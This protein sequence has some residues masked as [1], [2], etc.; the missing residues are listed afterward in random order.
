MVIANLIIKIRNATILA[1][2]QL[3]GNWVCNMF[4]ENESEW[5]Y[6][7][8]LLGLTLLSPQPFLFLSL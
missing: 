5:M 2:G 6:P 1:L 3:V 7:A 8:L 4:G